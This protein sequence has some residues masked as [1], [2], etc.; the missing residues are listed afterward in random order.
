MVFNADELN[1]HVFKYLDIDSLANVGLVNKNCRRISNDPSLVV[2]GFSSKARIIYRDYF[3]FGKLINNLKN[4]QDALDSKLLYWSKYIVSI[5]NYRSGSLSKITAIFKYLFPSF[6]KEADQQNDLNDKINDLKSRMYEI[7]IKF[8]PKNKINLS[9]KNINHGIGQGI[10][11]IDNTIREEAEHSKAE[12]RMLKELF[13]KQ[14]GFDNLP[15]WDIGNI[16]LDKLKQ[17]RSKM[18]APIMRGRD[19]KGRDFVALRCVIYNGIE[20]HWNT[21]LIILWR[22]SEGEWVSR[23]WWDFCLRGGDLRIDHLMNKFEKISMVFQDHKV[24]IERGERECCGSIAR[25]S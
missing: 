8:L 22:R 2:D 16:P 1:L 15:F 4:Y 19:R 20:A 17:S 25:L 23:L 5:L 24:L 3:E 21:D 18:T 7:A 12:A 9:D 10:R 13:A 14:G 6:K 11:D